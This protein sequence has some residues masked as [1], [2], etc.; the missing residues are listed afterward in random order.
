VN[1][2][3]E[4][5]YLTSQRSQCK[6]LLP[7]RIQLTPWAGDASEQ[8]RQAELCE[9]LDPKLL[10]GAQHKDLNRITIAARA[11]LLPETSLTFK[12]YPPEAASPFE[13]TPTSNTP[14]GISSKP[15]NTTGLDRKAMEQRR[16]ARSDKRKREPSREPSA[17]PELFNPLQGRPDAWQ[18]SESVDD[19]IRRLPPF[20]TS[21]FTCP[22]IWAE[23]PHR[24]PRDKSPCPCVD[25]FTIR[26]MEL[27]EQSLQTR[28]DI[29][30]KGSGGPRGVVTKQLHQESKALQ[31]RI[32]DLAKVTHVLS[33]KVSSIPLHQAPAV[34]YN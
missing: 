21:I 11:Q 24:N 17:K 18:L 3:H 5:E 32:T 12:S 2:S 15:F 19:F 1:T 10:W 14:S 29:Q 7:T 26:G 33:G 13:E 9:G 20:T 31:Q 25:D 30:K 4:L 28:R 6:D 23:N 16:L 34:F 8:E 27:L 22:W